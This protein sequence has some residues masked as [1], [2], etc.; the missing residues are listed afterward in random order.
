MACE[1][2]FK[3]LEKIHISKQW[4]KWIINNGQTTLAS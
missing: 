3:E 2:D 4:S 1:W